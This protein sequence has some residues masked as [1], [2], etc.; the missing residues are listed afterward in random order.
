MKAVIKDRAEPGIWVKEV[1]T[2]RPDSEEI[3]VRVKKA[4]ICGSDLGLYEFTPA[5]ASFAKLPTIPGH[6]FAGEVAELGQGVTQFEVGDHV[7]AESVLSCGTCQFCLNGQ[8]NLCLKF[9]IFG[10]HTNGGFSEYVA[11]PQKHLH[12]LNPALSFEEAAIIEPLSVCCHAVRDVAQISG[13]GTVLLLG[14]GPIGLLAGQVVRAEGSENVIVSGIGVDEARLSIASKL[15]FKTINS[16]RQDLVR[17][18]MAST[19]IG[20]DV[21]IVAAGSSRALAQGCEL[22]RKGGKVLNIAIYPQSVE[23][24]V[25]NLVRREIALLGTFGSVWKNYEEA[26]NLAANHKVALETLVTHRYPIDEAPT[27]FA[28]AKA[29]EGCKIQLVI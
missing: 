1:Q 10:I 23:L 14:P 25:T 15:G 11:V 16:D 24:P 19:R 2:P 7:V 9:R 28:K 17:E 22:V 21:A 18:V 29:K 5:Y 8:T 3:L 4:S 13:S 27:A 12:H 20:A 6:E 26:M